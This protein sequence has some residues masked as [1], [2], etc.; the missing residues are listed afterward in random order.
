VIE[1]NVAQEISKPGNVNPSGGVGAL[2][3]GVVKPVSSA[4]VNKPL[5]RCFSARPGS[6]ATWVSSKDS[7]QSEKDCRGRLLPAEL[8]RASRS[9]R[10]RVVVCGRLLH[11]R[12]Q[13]ACPARGAHGMSIRGSCAP[14]Q[15]LARRPVRQCGLPVGQ[16]VKSLI[17]LFTSGVPG[18]K[19]LLGTR[20][21]LRNATLPGRS[22]LPRDYLPR[23]NSNGS[24]MPRR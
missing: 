4:Y 1:E 16:N 24:K 9:T 12:L 17:F 23:S 15:D 7:C 18:A 14:H 20:G 10:Q 8:F 19:P 11:W 22:D 2:G 3:R 13:R 21:A 6:K 5:P